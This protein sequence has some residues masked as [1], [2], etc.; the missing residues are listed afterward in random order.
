MFFHASVPKRD[1]K[2]NAEIILMI[3]L[4]LQNSSAAVF[5]SPAREGR[6]R[7]VEASLP[8]SEN[9]A[10]GLRT[11]ITLSSR[12]LRTRWYS[13]TVIALVR[14][15]RKIQPKWRPRAPA[16]A[17]PHDHLAPAASIRVWKN[18]RWRLLFIQPRNLCGIGLGSRN[19]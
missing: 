13:V 16:F 18:P 19:L 3:V 17:C 9:F 8:C 11:L 7:L 1:R 6:G 10:A 4:D 15:V 12:W 5:H 14:R 2:L